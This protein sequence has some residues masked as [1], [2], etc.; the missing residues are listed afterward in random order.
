MPQT[1]DHPNET[2]PYLPVSLRRELDAL[3]GARTDTSAS[4]DSPS[5]LSL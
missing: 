3:R 1:H 4:A 5:D 2:R